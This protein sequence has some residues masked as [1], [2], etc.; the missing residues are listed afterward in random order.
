VIAS[1]HGGLPEIIHDRQTGRLVAPGSARALADAAAEL[2]DD[3][4]ERERLGAAAA[5]DVRR[6]FSTARLLDSIHALYDS[7]LV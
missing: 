6:R 4:S 7:L 3:S 1:G 5:S 2:L